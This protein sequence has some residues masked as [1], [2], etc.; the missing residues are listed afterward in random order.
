MLRCKLESTSLFNIA[1]WWCFGSSTMSS[2]DVNRRIRGE[3]P[4]SSRSVLNWQIFCTWKHQVQASRVECI[5][6]AVDWS[7][8]TWKKLKTNGVHSMDWHTK[9]SCHNVCEN[10]TGFHFENIKF[11]TELKRFE[12]PLVKPESKPTVKQPASIWLQ[13]NASSTN[14]KNSLRLFIHKRCRAKPLKRYIASQILH[15]QWLLKSEI[16]FH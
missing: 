14:S 9:A 2:F 7:I 6:Y 1:I 3:M 8:V 10:P 15:Q 16:Q 12:I 13:W 5:F 4:L 11:P